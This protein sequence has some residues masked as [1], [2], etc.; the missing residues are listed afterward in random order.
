M[1]GMMYNMG[2]RLTATDGVSPVI[3]RITLKTAEGSMAMMAFGKNIQ[4]AVSKMPGFMKFGT[5]GGFLGSMLKGAAIYGSLNLIQRGISGVIQETGRFETANLQFAKLIGNA[6]LATKTLKEMRIF[7]ASTPFE[8]KQAQE[9]SLGLLAAK[10]SAQELIPTMRMLGDLGM[11]DPEKVERL[12]YAF[13]KSKHLGKATWR[14]LSMFTTAGVPIIAQIREQLGLSEDAI[15]SFVRAG[16]VKFPILQKAVEDL[17]NS[18]KYK[19]MMLEMMA[20]IPGLWSNFKDII[21]MVQQELGGTFKDSLKSVIIQMQILGGKT[22]N[23]II[24][25]EDML[26]Q[27]IGGFFTKIAEALSKIDPQ[28]VF[29]AIGAMISFAKLAIITS[30]ALKTF[31]SALAFGGVLMTVIGKIGAFTAAFKAARTATVVVGGLM[32]VV[33]GKMGILAAASQALGVSLGAAF[34]PVTLAI[35]AV[36]A[37]LIAMRFLVAK[38]KGEKFFDFLPGRGKKGDATSLGTPLEQLS[39]LERITGVRTPAQGQGTAT[40]I[41]KGATDG[42][43]PKRPISQDAQRSLQYFESTSTVN[44]NS[45]ANLVVSLDKGLVSDSRGGLPPGVRLRGYNLGNSLA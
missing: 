33:A 41:I 4:R 39:M 23:W 5:G 40:Q 42:V 22:K 18:P 6:E 45:S 19:G 30:L 27:N 36:I 31:T 37:L 8:F 26:R 11:G 38:A 25:N 13:S 3:S 15:M 28:K 1:A 29:D 9:I 43:A 2:L 21:G 14:D 35:G 34:W 44:R 17:A 24:E 10:V 32:P 12:A 20:T 7:A 16:K